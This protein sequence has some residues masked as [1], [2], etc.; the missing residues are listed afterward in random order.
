GDP[1]Q[2]VFGFRGGEPAGLLAVDSPSVTLTQSHRCAPAVA[3]AVSG[4]ARRLPGGSAGRQIEGTGS[5]DG[6]VTVRLAASA[7]AEASMIA[8]ALRRAHLI[9]G[10]PW[11]QMAVIVRSV[12]RA[13]ARLPRALAAA[14]VPVALPASGGPLAE[15]PAAH[16]LLTVLASTAD[17]LDGERALALL[18]GPIGHVDPVSLRR[19]RRKLERA[20]AESSPTKLGDLLVEALT[21]DAPLH[22]PGALE[23]PA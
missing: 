2:A 4:V 15:E 3:R 20:R 21:G 13:A 18:T 14:G 12:P 10:V 23:F 22:G 9:D 8:D 1:N 7:H 11:S 16:A 17:G 5:D 6:S 19:L